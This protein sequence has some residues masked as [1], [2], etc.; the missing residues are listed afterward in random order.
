MKKIALLDNNIFPYNVHHFQF[1][2]AP[3][4]IVFLKTVIILFATK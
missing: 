3:L 1:V 4:T 2:T